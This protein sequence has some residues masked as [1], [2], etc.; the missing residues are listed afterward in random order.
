MYDYIC[1]VLAKPK[2]ASLWVQVIIKSKLFFCNISR[3]PPLAFE[4]LHPQLLGRD[5][6]LLGGLRRLHPIPVPQREDRL[7]HGG[8]NRYRVLHHPVRLYGQHVRIDED[9]CEKR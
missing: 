4:P 6:R 5:R 7:V 2:P 8:A 3:K 1:F 9:I